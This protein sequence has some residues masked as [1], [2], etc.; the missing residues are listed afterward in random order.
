M[1]MFFDGATDSLV[2]SVLNSIEWRIRYNLLEGRCP[3]SPAFRL[4]IPSTVDSQ[5]V[6]LEFGCFQ[7]ESAPISGS[8]SYHDKLVF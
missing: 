5:G 8:H 1:A 3:D 6:W 2:T 4:A 7:I